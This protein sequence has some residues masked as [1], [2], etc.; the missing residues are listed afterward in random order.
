MEHLTPRL[1]RGAR[2]SVAALWLSTAVV[3]VVQLHGSSAALLSRTD[4]PAQSHN[5][6]IGAGA[7]MD[8]AM[9]MAIW[10]SHRRLVYRLAMANLLLMTA[11]AT[12]LLPS[13]WFDP[14]G[15]LTKNLPIAALLWIL[16]RDAAK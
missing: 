7:A 14:L 15:S 6:L 16:H 3:S 4:L 2:A 8:A 5:T 9:G 12:V 13:L 10:F 1:L 11:V